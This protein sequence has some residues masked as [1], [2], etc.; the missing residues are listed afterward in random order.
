M[1]G[2]EGMGK[3]VYRSYRTAVESIRAMKEELDLPVS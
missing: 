2:K 1:G 3:E